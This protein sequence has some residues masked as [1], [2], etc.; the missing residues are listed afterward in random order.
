MKWRHID[1]QQLQLNNVASHISQQDLVR[2]LDGELRQP[3]I[4]QSQL[5]AYLVR[6]LTYLT[7]DRGFTLTALVRARFQLAQAWPRD[8]PA[9]TGSN[10]QGV[11]RT[12][13]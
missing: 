3:D 1:A 10:G 6:M 5:Q 2:W 9:A 7:V 4:G 8:Q 12:S 13:G 11:P